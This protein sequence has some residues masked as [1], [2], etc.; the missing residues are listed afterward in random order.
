MPNLQ[1]QGTEMKGPQ[2]TYRHQRYPNHTAPGNQSLA[3]AQSP[4]FPYYGNMLC[5]SQTCEWQG[6]ITL[7]CTKDG[8]WALTQVLKQHLFHSLPFSKV[9][10]SSAFFKCS[11]GFR[12][13]QAPGAALIVGLPLAGGGWLGEVRRGSSGRW[14]LHRAAHG[15]TDTCWAPV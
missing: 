7:R 3:L 8:G 10:Q 9:E 11:K 2:R 4:Y 14:P 5:L 12:E 15:Q 6:Q 1:G 13:L